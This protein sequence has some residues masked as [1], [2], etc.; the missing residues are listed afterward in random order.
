MLQQWVAAG[1]PEGDKQGPAGR[2]RHSSAEWPLGKPDLV[3]KMPKAYHVPAE[4]RDIYRN[5]AVALDLK[6]DKWVRAIDFRPSASVGRASHA[7]L[8][9]P[10]RHG[11]QERSC[12]RR[13]RLQRRHERRWADGGKGKRKGGLG[14]LG[15]LGALG[16]EGGSQAGNL[17]LGGWALGAQARAAPRWPRLSPPQGR[18]PDPLHALPP[19]RQGRGRSLHRRPLLRRQAARPALHR[20]ADSLRLRHPRR[21]RHPRRQ[22]RLRHRGF[23]RPPRRCQGL[24]HQRPRPLHRQGLQDDRD[25]AR[26]QDQD[27]AA[28]SRLGFR[29]AG[30]VSVPGFHRSAEGNQ[31]AT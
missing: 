14:G 6:E 26:W 5:F 23:L 29:L 30:T 31:A 15:G 17:G 9:R 4:G 12:Q 24:R 21:H 25:A 16:G 7:V 28:H 10:H 11:G 3:V 22:E 2:S 8:P 1:M 27:A 13:G 19:L 18:R 20:H